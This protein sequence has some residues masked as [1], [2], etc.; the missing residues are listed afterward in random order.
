MI[1]QAESGNRPYAIE[2]PVLALAAASQTF[3]SGY[4]QCPNA[5]HIPLS[6]G[7]I[8]PGYAM[9]VL[10]WLVRCVKSKTSISFIP[11][12]PE[13]DGED[14]WYW[15]YSYAAMR[16]L[17]LEAAQDL[18]QFVE[19]LIDHESLVVECSSFLRLLRALQ[20]VDPIV[21]HLAGRTGMQMLENRLGL[22]AVQ[23]DSISAAHP[24]FAALVNEQ[25]QK[26][27]C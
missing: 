6:I 11:I 24:H 23:C 9:C 14:K 15:P 8:L 2:F 16:A 10:D 19:H 13:I 18:Q 5:S 27:T 17:G 12:E 26:G 7:N 20:P 25:I 21:A 4:E 3:R 22:S 1:E